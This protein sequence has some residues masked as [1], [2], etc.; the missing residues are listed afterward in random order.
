MATP[1]QARRDRKRIR[2][3]KPCHWLTDCP[4]AAAPKREPLMVSLLGKFR[5]P[6][7]QW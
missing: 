3:G 6:A 5:R 2:Q 4:P 7:K 1:A